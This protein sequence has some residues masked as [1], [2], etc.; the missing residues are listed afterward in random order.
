LISSC[1]N[2]THGE[3]KEPA[4]SETRPKKRN[5]HHQLKT[6]LFLTTLMDH[7]TNV[8][9]SVTATPVSENTKVSDADG[10]WVEPSATEESVRPSSNAVVSKPE[11]HTTSPAQLI[12]EPLIARVTHATGQP[13]N[14]L[15]VMTVNSQMP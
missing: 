8:T 4:C 2:V 13:R 6:S 14:A 12:S 3:E 1:G 11:S 5:Q 10:A 7:K 15:R 9:V